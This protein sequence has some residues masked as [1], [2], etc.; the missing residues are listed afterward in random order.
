MKNLELL[1][2]IVK[3][4]E[5]RIITK[6]YKGVNEK[7]EFECKKKHRWYTKPTSIFNGHWCPTCNRTVPYTI[8]DMKRVARERGGECLSH[9]Y[10]NAHTKLTWKCGKGH[11][12]QAIPK[13]IYLHGTWCAECK[14]VKKLTIKDIKELAK[15]NNGICLSME[16][17]NNRGKLRWRCKK[18]HEWESSTSNIKSGKWCPRC[19]KR[20]VI[21]DDMKDLAQSRG[22]KCLSSNYTGKYAKLIWKCNEGH[23]WESTPAIIKRGSWCPVCSKKSKLTITDIDRLA[24]EKGGKCQSIYYIN[25]KTRLHFECKDGHQ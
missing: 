4:K 20:K 9:H 18:G 2:S 22:G 25:S 8:E 12:W 17:V 1:Q 7:I 13:S 19:A 21:I 6:E 5:G 15:Q 14:G 11:V 24:A 16:Y 10:Q 23:V 3:R